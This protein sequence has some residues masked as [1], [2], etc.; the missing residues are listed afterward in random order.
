MR[1]CRIICPSATRLVQA[2]TADASRP[3]VS[4]MVEGASELELPSGALL[5]YFVDDGAPGDS[6]LLVYHHGTPAAGPLDDD[7]VAPARAH[8]LRVVELVRPGYGRSSREPGRSVVDVA[9]LVAAL[10]DALGHD[11]FVGMG[12]SGGGPH[13]LATA[14]LL[15][16]RCVATFSLASVAPY[17]AS[18][19]DFLDG[20]GQDNLDEFGAAVA[21]DEPLREY[22]DAAG[23]ELR[24]VTGDDVVDSLASLL[25]DADRAY[26]TGEVADRMAEQVRWSVAPAIWG[27]FDDDLAFLRPWGFDP[28]DVRGPVLLWQGSDDLM[29]PQAHG[30]WLADRIPEV[31]AALVPGEGHLSM[32]TRFGEAFAWLRARLE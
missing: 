17:D 4:G 7:L 16:D 15:P 11:R 29:V 8:G 5:Q 30:A 25:P 22:L 19:L 3:M 26:L 9:P 27:W 21:G 14:A 23:D 1:R 20:M 32:A 24:T 12:W 28:G 13:A 31:S 2:L 6:A 18:G 10:A